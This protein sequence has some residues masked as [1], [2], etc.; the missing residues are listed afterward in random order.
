M[1]DPDAVAALKYSR[2][3][4]V[5]YLCNTFSI[6]LTLASAILTLTS[7]L[8]L[9]AARAGVPVNCTLTTVD[10]ERDPI[11]RSITYVRTGCADAVPVTHL[12]PKNGT[13]AVGD[14][15]PCY[16]LHPDDCAWPAVVMP[17]DLSY[18]VWAAFVAILAL[19]LLVNMGLG[20]RYLRRYWKAKGLLAA[21]LQQMELPKLAQQKTA[22]ALEASP[23][24]GAEADAETDASQALLPAYDAGPHE[25]D[26]D[27]AWRREA[28]DALWSYLNC[29]NNSA[30]QLHAVAGYLHQPPPR[31]LD[32]ETLKKALIR[33]VDIGNVAMVR[34]LLA[35]GADV[36]AQEDLALEI[37][38]RGRHSTLVDVLLAAGA[39]VTMG[40]RAGGPGWPLQFAANSGSVEIV[41][42]LLRYGADPCGNNNSPVKLAI[43]NGHLPVVKLLVDAGANVQDP[44]LLIMAANYS[45]TDIVRYLIMDEG[46]S[47]SILPQQH[48]CAILAYNDVELVSL[49]VEAGAQ[50]SDG[51]EL[52]YRAI[53]FGCPAMVRRLLELGVPPDDT[54]MQLARSAEWGT[55]ELARLLEEWQTQHSALPPLNVSV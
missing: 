11:G 32:P 15:V 5:I 3:G 8:Q 10:D 14:L 16:T 55:D 46:L 28:A 22:Q 12:V 13:A 31:A 25:L 36:H 39:D 45:H 9:E 27:A 21:Q 6:A 7:K 18:A 42:S 2:I 35:S 48:F 26:P 38:I 24:A 52:L 37:A 34:L 50:L 30:K 40:H 43:A 44:L 47:A 20:I 53:A 19:L 23:D 54:A 49:L 4:I 29:G 33:S 51:P 17:N 41:R 1:G